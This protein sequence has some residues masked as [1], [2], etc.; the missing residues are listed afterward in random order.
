[1][2]SAP[3]DGNRKVPRR[4]RRDR[5]ASAPSPRPVCAAL[6]AGSLIAVPAFADTAAARGGDQ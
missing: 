1:M 3:D 6:G 5:G 2:M 4:D